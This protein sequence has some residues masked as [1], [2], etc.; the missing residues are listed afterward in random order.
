M[1]EISQYLR[2]AL[3]PPNTSVTVVRVTITVGLFVVALASLA[4][5]HWLN[6]AFGAMVSAG[7]GLL[8][9]RNFLH[10]RDRRDE[11]PDRVVDEWA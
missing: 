4:M 9:R 2:F 11:A 5:T 6:A 1:S 3:R 10:W 8:L 7:F